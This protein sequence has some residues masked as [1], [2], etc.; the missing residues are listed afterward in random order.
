MRT[1]CALFPRLVDRLLGRPGRDK[2]GIV[3][4][5]KLGMVTGQHPTSL[6]A[7]SVC[8]YSQAPPAKEYTGIAGKIRWHEKTFP[9]LE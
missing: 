4:C 9:P 2:D 6:F 7:S 8:N 1:G 5:K 3:L